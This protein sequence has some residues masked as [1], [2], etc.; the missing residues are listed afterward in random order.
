MLLWHNPLDLTSGELTQHVQK[1]IECSSNVQKT[2]VLGIHTGDEL[3]K[4][5]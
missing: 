1:T 4:E 2:I 3:C 5:T